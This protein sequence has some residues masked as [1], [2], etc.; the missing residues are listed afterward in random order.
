MNFHLKFPELLL[1]HMR[2]DLARPHPF[3][4]ERVGFVS[5]RVAD[6]DGGVALLGHGYHTVA[7]D[8]YAD[9]PRFPAM[10][11]PGAIRKALELAYNERAAM[12]H[13]HVH[14]HRGKPRFSGIDL[15]EYPKFIPD[16][17]KVQPELPHGALVLS[18]D[19]AIALVWY[20]GKPKPTLADEIWSVGTRMKRL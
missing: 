6:F 18:R 9:N 14:D 2:T 11:G 16:F 8:D 3:A 12:I 5:C 15:S 13:V 10:M 1:R 4:A 20:P 17:W 7:D 19:Q